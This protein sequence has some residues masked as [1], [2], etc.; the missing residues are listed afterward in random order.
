MKTANNEIMNNCKVIIERLNDAFIKK[1]INEDIVFPDEKAKLNLLMIGEIGHSLF[2]NTIKMIDPKLPIKEKAEFTKIN[3]KFTYDDRLTYRINNNQDY[4]AEVDLID[5]E[6][7]LMEETACFD[8]PDID[9]TLPA[10]ILKK[11]NISIINITNDFDDFNWYSTLTKADFC[12]LSLS[13]IKLLS[14]AEKE[15]IRNQLYPLVGRERMGI[16]L[17]NYEKIDDKGKKEIMEYVDIFF[18]K[19]GVKIATFKSEDNK[20]I[21]YLELEDFI[22]NQLIKQSR[23]YRGLTVKNNEDICIKETEDALKREQERYNTDIAKLEIIMRK[24]EKSRKDLD[25]SKDSAKRRVDIFVNANIKVEMLEKIQ[26]FNKILIE[27]MKN[28]LTTGHEFE[29]MQKSF[30]KYIQYI[31]KELLTYLQPE[32]TNLIK[33]E[34]LKI[35]DDVQNEILESLS[36]NLDEND[37]ALLVNTLCGVT[38]QGVPVG[39]VK[40]TYWATDVTKYLSLGGGLL[41]LV[42]WPLGLIALGSAVLTHKFNKDAIEKEKQEKYTEQF[43]NQADEIYRTILKQVS[44]QFVSIIDELKN[45]VETSFAQV[46]DKMMETLQ[47]RKLEIEKADDIRNFIAESLQNTIPAL[48]NRK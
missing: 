3:C 39:K 20:E 9:I 34:M 16:N 7:T 15:F 31:W 2:Y 18:N 24:L 43:M 41:F 44:T 45:N 10:D 37:G 11:T 22:K 46:L 19:D 36:E 38:V 6:K 13:A 42:S 26:K 27:N 48:R 23:L 4:F 12:V 25:L 21:L 14:L 47:N 35:S 28:C 8:I 5:L 40:S 32:I 30:I 29:K 33:H 17:H 1:L